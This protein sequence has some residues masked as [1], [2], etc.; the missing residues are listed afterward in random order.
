MSGKKQRIGIFGG[1]FNPPHIAHVRVADAFVKALSLDKLLIIPTNDPPHKFYSGNVSAADR[2]KMCEIAFS[3]VPK[4]SVSDIEIARGG[5]SYT[6]KTLETI[7]DD[8]KEIFLMCGTDM[9][10]SLDTWFQAE[11]IFEMATICYVRRETDDCVDPLINNAREKYVSRYGASVVEIPSQVTV[12]SSTEIRERLSQGNYS[13]I[14]QAVA[15][16]IRERK[17][18]L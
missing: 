4:A 7:K 9:F 18:Y 1:T 10:L 17:L 8:G 12:V 6:V 13:D 14:P 2:M 15:E 3:S 11:K 5:K 16:Y